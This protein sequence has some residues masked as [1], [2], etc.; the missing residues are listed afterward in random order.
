MTILK[1]IKTYIGFISDELIGDHS[2]KTLFDNYKYNTT[3]DLSKISSI[4]SDIIYKR[5]ICFEQSFDFDILNKMRDMAYGT[6]KSVGFHQNEECDI[7][8]QCAN[9]HGEV[10]ELW[11]AYRKGTLDEPCDKADKMSEP[12]TCAEEE[13]ADI[14]IRCCDLAADLKMDLGR[15]VRIKNEFNKTRPYRNGGKKA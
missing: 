11:E 9:L 12:L 13:V 4:D 3:L 10:S 7:P 6:A 14:F 2:N 1:N 8:A 5:N 15:A